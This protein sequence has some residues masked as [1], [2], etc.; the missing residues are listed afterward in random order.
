MSDH[1]LTRRN[2]LAQPAAAAAAGVVIPHALSAATGKRPLG[3]VKP[4]LYSITYLGMWYR[5][6]ALSLEQVVQRAKAYGY[7][8]IEI[9]GKRPHGCALDWPKSRCAQFRT[10]VK[11][12]GLAISGVA[13]DND[14]SSPVPEVRESQLANIRDLVRMTSDL[15]A[16]VL[17]VFLAWYG[18]TKLPEGGGRYD[19]S[20]KVWQYTHDMFI[21]EETWAW[22]RECL[23]EAAKFAG[24]YGVTLALQNHKPVIKTYHDVLTMIKEVNSP[25]LKACIDAP[26]M[27][28]RDAAYLRQA[29]YDTGALQVQSHFGGDFEQAAPGA[30]IRIRGV[31][32]QW[33]GPYIYKGFQTEDIYTPFIQALIE[34]GYRGYIGYELCHP[35]PVINGKTVGINYVDAS[36]KLA[37]EYIR[38][39]IA[40]ARKR[41]A[42]Q[43]SA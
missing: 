8:G 27:E 39:I 36:T 6:D 38:G 43:P 32:G 11:D 30:P 16:K 7:D 14:F 41:A 35:L 9:Q 37:A 2:F 42:A 29:V 15:G 28:K 3:E 21:E 4:A 25:H 19:L 10:L 26:I 18:S 24:E 34:T 20:Q 23:I 12:S 22:C 33:G 31:Q 40:E 17:R 1:I 13:A 5:G